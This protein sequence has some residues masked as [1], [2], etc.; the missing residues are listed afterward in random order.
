MTAALPR[1]LFPALLLGLLPE[2]GWANRFETI[3]GGLSGSQTLKLEWLRTFS[4]VAGALCLFGALLAVVVPRR[5]PLYLNY[6]NWKAS[7]AV[8]GVFGG[9]FLLAWLLL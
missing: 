7:A 8:L 9:L 3:S 2:L 4:L 6:T 5:N 1:L